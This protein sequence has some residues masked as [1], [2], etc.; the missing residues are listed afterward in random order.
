VIL[1]FWRAFVQAFREAQ[2]D[3][4]RPRLVLQEDTTLDRLRNLLPKKQSRSLDSA[5]DGSE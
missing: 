1:R 5:A 4:R 2:A 3:A